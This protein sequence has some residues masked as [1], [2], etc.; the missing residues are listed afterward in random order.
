MAVTLPPAASD[1]GAKDAAAATA[2]A[3]RLE[4]LFA[5]VLVEQEGPALADEVQSLYDAA[6]A[7]RRDEPGAEAALASIV[8]GARSPML[9]IR[10]CMVELALANITDELRR[11][12]EHRAG[13]TGGDPPPASLPEAAERIKRHPEAADALDVRLVLT[14]HPTDMARR[15]VLGNQRMASTAME[16]LADPRLGAT[17]RAALEDEIR[18]GLAVWWATGELRAM[19]PRV[20]DEVR[21]KLF[22]FDKVLFDAAGELAFQYARVVGE[23]VAVES[24]PVRFG[25]WA[26]ADMDGNPNVTSQTILETLQAQRVLV[27]ELLR[28][29]I[30]PLRRAFSQRES[31]LPMTD[32]LRES[33]ARDERQLPDQAAYLVARYPHEAGEPL[34][35]KLAF[36]L[37]RIDNTL[38]SAR[39]GQPREPGYASPDELIADLEAIRSSLG[40][41]IV[42][43]GRI[44]RVIW[45]VRIFGFHLATLEARD[46]APEL[47]D[48]CRAL[49]PGYG[50]AESEERRAELLTDACLA[51]DVPPRPGGDRPRAAATFDTIA[52]AI[53]TY[54][55]AGIDTFIVSNAEQPSDVLCALWLARASGLFHPGNEE[56]VEGRSQIEIVPLFERRVALENSTDT[57]QALYANPAYAAHLDARGRGQEVMIGYS[58]A[59]KDEGFMPAQWS[60]YRA[61]EALAGQARENDVNLRLFH[62]RGGSPPR[63]GGPSSRT[64]LGQ[65]PGTVGGRIKITEQG[66]V[67]T[68]KFS[69]PQLAVR[70]LEQTVATVVHATVDPAPEPPEA[71]RTE[72]E[73]LADAGRSTYH[74]LVRDEDFLRVLS[75]CT[76]LALMDELNI[77]SR[78]SSRKPKGAFSDLRA[79]P[80]VFAWM[81]TRIGLPSWYGAGTALAG[82]DL[83]LQRELWAEWPFFRN[84]IT[85]LETAM[86]ASD[87]AI[88]ERYM[89]FADDQ[90][91]AERVWTA[92]RDEHERCIARLLE[93]TG[94]ERLGDPTPDALERFDRRVPWLDALS[95]FQLSLLERDR[96]GDEDARDPLLATVAGIATGL[97]TTG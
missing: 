62:G 36:V 16:Q 92:I 42:A 86:A 60:M 90:E 71:W 39:G 54:G 97:R 63:G 24:P 25:S 50:A 4:R 83:D 29:R 70:S 19:R 61:Q 82:G 22:F 51:D 56:G 45:Q 34:R 64:I 76:P 67:I 37:A 18:E 53:A 85:T 88:G 58:D 80:W 94:H 77:A 9:L 65:P 78:P 27:L 1:A 26:G 35:R 75:E 49:L 23:E 40:S 43:R 13:D 66:E 93:I 84:V 91:V 96:A 33:L 72:M 12:R 79:I 5:D 17:E 59:G 81:Q 21:R 46:S 11:V 52:T 31:A 32:E 8:D 2:D 20:I 87:L 6:A 89:A 7:V 38:D 41:K 48:A 44:A 57:M 15:S 69:H 55:R 68:A 28:D 47:H 95:Y 14:A 30:R 73:R 3:E 10:A 74:D